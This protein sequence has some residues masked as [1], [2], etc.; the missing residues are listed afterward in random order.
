M[1]TQ[2]QI[3][4]MVED[5]LAN[6]V[7]PRA[8]PERVWGGASYGGSVCSACDEPISL[9]KSELEV[10]CQDGTL[11]RY[12]VLCFSVLTTARDTLASADQVAGSA[13]GSVRL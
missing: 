7:L 9:G 1:P 6:G 8:M 12:H 5:K 10:E 2:N 13:A 3:R 4:A 11:R